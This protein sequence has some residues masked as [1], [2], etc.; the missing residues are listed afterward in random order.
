MQTNHL[1]ELGSTALTW[2]DSRLRVGRIQPATHRAARWHIR[3]LT[4]YLGGTTPIS[5]ITVD[6]LTL[7]VECL[8]DDGMEIRSRNQ[9]LST[10]RSLF[11]WATTTGLITTDPMAGIH[12]VRPPRKAVRAVP[13]HHVSLIL[14]HAD[15]RSRAIIVLLA[16]IGFR[17]GEL[18][19]IRWENYQPDTGVLLI[20]QGKGC[21]DRTVVLER[22]PVEA[23][24]AWRAHCSQ[25]RTVAEGPV[26]V[27]PVFP[28]QRAGQSMSPG[29]LYT[30]VVEAAARAGLHYSPH[31]Y[32]HTCG[33]QW[34]RRGAS[35]AVV[36]R[37]LGHADLSSAAHYI[38]LDVEDLRP[39]V[40]P[41]R[42]YRGQW[43][44]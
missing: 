19:G 29:R 26:E 9:V 16:Q 24:A 5:N 13:P 44:S 35:T 33:T 4:E 14:E 31:Q 17:R 18:A 21:K 12:N 22:E 39:H 10:A 43:T 1:A 30:L 38:E 3:K 2:N 23:L 6:D 41:A 42:Y 32:R 34:T 28:G 7:W 27:G 15:L 8:A 37:Q 25:R 40:A 11:S 20:E 36:A